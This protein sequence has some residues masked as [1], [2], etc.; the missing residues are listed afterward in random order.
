[1]VIEN[2]PSAVKISGQCSQYQVQKLDLALVQKSFS[3]ED[4]TK[5]QCSF[6]RLRK[7]KEDTSLDVKE[8]GQGGCEF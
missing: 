5:L 7:V 8:R 3:E 1:M 2:Q 6:F 4:G